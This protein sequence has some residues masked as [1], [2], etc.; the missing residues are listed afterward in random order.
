MKFKKIAMWASIKY[1]FLWRESGE[2]SGQ[3]EFWVES[4]DKSGLTEVKM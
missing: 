3:D 1:A 2:I 4:K